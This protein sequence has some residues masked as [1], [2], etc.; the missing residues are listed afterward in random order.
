MPQDII[1]PQ[2]QTRK[3]PRCGKTSLKFDK[4]SGRLYCPECGFEQKIPV[5]G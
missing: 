5:M 2:P 1:E 4:K 3:C